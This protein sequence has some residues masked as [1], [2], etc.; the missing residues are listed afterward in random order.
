VAYAFTK[1][2]THFMPGNP[3]GLKTGCNKLQDVRGVI[4]APKLTT[5]LR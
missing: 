1:F 4:G 2:S 5:R 3:L